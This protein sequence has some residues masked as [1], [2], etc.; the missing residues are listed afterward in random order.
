MIRVLVV[1]DHRVVRAGLEALIEEQADIELVSSAAGGAE[2]IELAKR[3]RPDVIIM[4]ISMPDVDGVEATRRILAENPD[5]RIMMLSS[6]GDRSR[7]LAA[8]QAGA[9]GY[10]LK[11]ADTEDLL[12]AIRTTARG[13]APLDP[14]VARVLVADRAASGGAPLSEREREVLALVASGLSNKQIARRLGIVEATVK[15]HLTNIFTRIGATDRT[16]A[17]IWAREHGISSNK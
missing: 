8:V 11:D 12:R 7:V 15:T 4:D 1:D 6:F 9:V 3:T 10:V 5:A 2:A 17:A 16:Q 13:D 14:R